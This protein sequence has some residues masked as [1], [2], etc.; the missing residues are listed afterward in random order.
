MAIHRTGN[1]T[2]E[3]REGRV[4]LSARDPLVETLLGGILI[5]GFDLEETR[6]FCKELARDRN[7]WDVQR[8]SR[9][10]FRPCR[11]NKANADG[12]LRKALAALE[13][14]AS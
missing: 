10:L 6:R 14:G 13:G 5:D 12:A 3:K 1:A 7:Q 9:G 11:L 8:R 2:P 4:R